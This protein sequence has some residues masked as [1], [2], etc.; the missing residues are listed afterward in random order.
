MSVEQLRDLLETM[1]VKGPIID[2]GCLVVESQRL[3]L[4]Q[5]NQT[6]SEL[7]ELQGWLSTTQQVLTIDGVLPALTHRILQADLYKAE[8]DLT[9]VIRPD[10]DSYSLRKIRRSNDPG[11]ILVTRAYLSIGGDHKLRYET[12][13]QS[14]QSGMIAGSVG[15]LPGVTRFKGFEE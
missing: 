15:L 13:W 7:G 4:E 5:L 8:Q 11:G 12:A 1:A 10:G 3:S 2:S 14:L 9:L 6:L